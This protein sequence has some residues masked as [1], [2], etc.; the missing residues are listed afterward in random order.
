MLI[1]GY[2]LYRFADMR[3]DAWSLGA[4]FGVCRGSFRFKGLQILVPAL[5]SSLNFRVCGG[6]SV[7]GR[8]LLMARWTCCAFLMEGFKQEKRRC[9]RRLIVVDHF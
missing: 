6:D 4:N 9:F 5:V 3:K 8:R 2:R 1:I 7:G